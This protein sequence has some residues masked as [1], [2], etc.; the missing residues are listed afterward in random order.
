MSKRIPEFMMRVKLPSSS[1]FHSSPSGDTE[2][3]IALDKA[4]GTALPEGFKVLWPKRTQNWPVDSEG[5]TYVR[6]ECIDPDGAV[7]FWKDEYARARDAMDK[8]H[9]LA[10][11]IMKV[12]V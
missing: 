2:Y 6:L 7:A 12:S 3:E 5:F 8:V 10:S 4:I 11:E 9:A 1:G